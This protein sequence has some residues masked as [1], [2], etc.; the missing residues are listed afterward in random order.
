VIYIFR[1]ELN[2]VCLLSITTCN[3]LASLRYLTQHIDFYTD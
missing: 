2:I 3:V 1:L